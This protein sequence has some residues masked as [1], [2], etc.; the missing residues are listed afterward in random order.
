MVKCELLKTLS[1]LRAVSGYEEK[2]T[3]A[4]VDMFSKHSDDVYT[5]N[6]GNIIA[7]KK[8]L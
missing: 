8:F 1:E 5:D 7:V 3:S 6:L 4:I 2:V